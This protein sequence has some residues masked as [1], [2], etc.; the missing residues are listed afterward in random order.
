MP[1]F[2]YTLILFVF[3]LFPLH[4][5]I[6]TFLHFVF[7]GGSIIVCRSIQRI[8]HIVEFESD[9]DVV[10]SILLPICELEQEHTLQ[11]VVPQQGSVFAYLP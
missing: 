9:V 4:F 3:G 1:L 10:K 7:L 6:L 5:F 8:V 11:R 2:F